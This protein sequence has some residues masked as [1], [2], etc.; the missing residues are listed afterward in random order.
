MGSKA[1]LSHTIN[2]P[3]RTLK[4][5]ATPGLNNILHNFPAATNLT[6]SPQFAH[7]SSTSR[8]FP[9]DLQFNIIIR[10]QVF[11]LSYEQ[12]MYDEPNLFTTAFLDGFSEADTRTLTIPGRSPVL[13]GYIYEYLSGYAI[14]PNPDI[15]L[16][17]LASDCE[18]YGLQRLK[19]QL[20]L[21]KLGDA[22]SSRHSLS[23]V[24]RFEDVV[25]RQAH[26]VDWTEN[27]LVDTSDP[28]IKHILVFLTKANFRLDLT[29]KSNGECAQA[30]FGIEL[31][32]YATSLRSK[33]L[34]F[35]DEG[36]TDWTAIMAEALSATP[37]TLND[38]EFEGNFGD[39]VQ[40]VGSFM[41]R[42]SAGTTS[43]SL[44]T[45]PSRSAGGLQDPETT[46]K[47]SKIMPGL[48]ESMRVRSLQGQNTLKLSTS[49][50]ASHM[51]LIIAPPDGSST[52][53]DETNRNSNLVAKVL[54]CSL[55]TGLYRRKCTKPLVNF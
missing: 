12:I 39:L 52:T 10:G 51:S 18:Y 30:S 44:S 19:D 2:A 26:A 40:W 48:S 28:A 36:L 24:V 35:R 31:P 5:S 42:F 17:N 7:A 33:P 55:S 29:V 54:N 46:E 8:I 47:L 43:S 13:F 25:T 23:R 53:T 41:I 6:T 1:V 22:L 9:H 3:G 11:K 37:L 49:F 20:T 16:R 34:S 32:P 50:W 21:P 15:D 45:G 14:L 38:G 27:G 4:V